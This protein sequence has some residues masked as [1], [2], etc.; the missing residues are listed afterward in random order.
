MNRFVHNSILLREW[1]SFKSIEIV[2]VAVGKYGPRLKV[3]SYHEM[4][5]I[6]KIKSWYIQRI[7][8][9]PRGGTGAMWMLKLSQM[10]GQIGRTRPR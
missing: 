9:G 2:S 1:N 8:E 6:L 3:A 5:S 4:S 7:C 10:L